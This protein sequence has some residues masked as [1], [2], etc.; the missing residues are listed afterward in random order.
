MIKKIMLNKQGIGRLLEK[1]SFL[2]PDEISLEFLSEGYDLSNAFISLRNGKKE[3][4]FRLSSPFKIPSEFLFAGYLNCRVTLYNGSNVAKKWDILP[5]EIIEVPT[6]TEMR[7]YLGELEEK[8]VI[9][10]QKVEYLEK[11]HE[12][13][14]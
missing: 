10:Q 2:L 12:I 4:V 8:L 3:G 13:I 9:L 11:Q 7:D 5:I 6:G 1:E 14:K